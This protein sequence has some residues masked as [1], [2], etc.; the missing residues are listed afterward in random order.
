MNHEQ[1]FQSKLTRSFISGRPSDDALF[2]FKKKQVI[3]SLDGYVVMP[4]EQF[5]KL[6][7]KKHRF[8]PDGFNDDGTKLDGTDAKSSKSQ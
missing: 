4:F 6:V 1:D 3:A 8:V 5:N 7:A 2:L